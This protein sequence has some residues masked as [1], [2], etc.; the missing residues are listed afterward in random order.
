MAKKPTLDDLWNDAAPAA[1]LFRPDQIAAYP[2]AV[3]RYLEHAISPGAP[4]A[5]AVR[6]RMHG[7]I[8]LKRWYPFTAEQVIHFPR[9]MIWRAAVRMRGLPIR[10]YDRVLEGEGEMRWKLLGLIPFVTASGPDITR[11]AAGRLAPELMWLPPALCRPDVAWTAQDDRHVRARIRVQGHE[12][13]MELTLD[14]TG[15]LAMIK[16]ERWGNPEGGAFRKTSFGAILEA[17][18]VFGGFTIPS[19]MR[20]GWHPETPRFETE[21]EFFRATIDHAA[22]R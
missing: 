5:S 22:Y 4:L 14:E 15:R 17:E 11:S 1:E 21:G 10:G 13:E 6:L 20:V 9:G 8:K 12:H 7:E 2:T 3:R 19:R 18:S 16:L